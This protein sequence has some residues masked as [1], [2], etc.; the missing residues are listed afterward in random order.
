MRCAVCCRAQADCGS[1]RPI[2][3]AVRGQWRV[4]DNHA[5]TLA[6]VGFALANRMVHTHVAGDIF[7][8]NN[9]VRVASFFHDVQSGSRSTA[10]AR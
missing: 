1:M 6:G 2:S 4:I 8:A 5:E 10:A 7:N 3:R 9:A